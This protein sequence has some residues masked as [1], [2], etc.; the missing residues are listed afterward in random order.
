[1]NDADRKAFL[2]RHGIDTTTVT[3][4]HGSWLAVDE[5]GLRQLADLA[6]DPQAAHALVDQWLA[7]TRQE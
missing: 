1:M 5:A 3:D 6:P 4:R 2:A 7:E